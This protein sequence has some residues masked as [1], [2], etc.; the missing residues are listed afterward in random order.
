VQLECGHLFHRQCVLSKVEKKWPGVRI[1]FGFLDCPICKGEMKHPLLEP[2]KKPLMELREMLKSKGLARLKIEGMLGDQKLVDPTSRYYKKPEA[3]AMDSFAYYNCFKCSKFYFGGKRDCEQNAAADDRPL[4]E[5]IC[6]DCSPMKNVHC[7]I[8]EHQEF[9]LW[10]CRFCCNP[11][12]WF[13]FG[14]THFCEPCHK[15]N[16]MEK[17]RRARSG[18]PQCKG[19]LFC[20]LKV[21]HS[22][23]G[24]ETE[25]EYSLGCGLCSEQKNKIDEAR[26]R[27]EKVD[28]VAS[29]KE[30]V[31]DP[32][33]G[34]PK[35]D[36]PPSKGKGKKKAKS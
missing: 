5:F 12:V 9:H 6:Y 23:N 21:D 15:D 25:C 10:K 29:G 26:K 36:R 28:A 16:P 17:T 34:P 31:A 13:C 20:P 11:A 14:T 7:K 24:C 27:E 3:Y 18:F 19:R 22:P 4:E 33:N 35:L 30:S 2:P 8:P 32:K 1:T